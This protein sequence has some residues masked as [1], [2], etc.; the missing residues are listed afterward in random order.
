MGDNR[1]NS[2]DS[3]YFGFVDRDV[4]IGKAKRV[5]VSLDIGDKYQ[6]RLNRFLA[7]LD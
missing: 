2:K 5:L 7:P 3:R 6:P 1:D 4:I